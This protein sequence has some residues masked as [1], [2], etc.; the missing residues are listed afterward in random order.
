MPARPARTFSY[1]E[2]GIP[3]YSGVSP[4]YRSELNVRAGTKR[5][6]GRILNHSPRWKR[7]ASPSVA[8]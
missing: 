1:R 4:E 8:V 2:S 3:E 6:Y 5:A 7:A